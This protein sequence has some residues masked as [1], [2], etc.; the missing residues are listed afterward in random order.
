MVTKKFRNLA[1]FGLKMGGFW[2]MTDRKMTR[3]QLFLFFCGHPLGGIK[4]P[5]EGFFQIIFG[6]SRAQNLNF[7]GFH[8]KN[9]VECTLGP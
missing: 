7:W 9:Q 5:K 2:V 6:V 8:P 4:P 1:L 3:A